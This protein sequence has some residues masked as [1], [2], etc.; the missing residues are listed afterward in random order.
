MSRY[1]TYI[2]GNTVRKDWSEGRP[3]QEGQQ[4]Q[5]KKVSSQVKKNRNKAAHMNKGYVL[6]L[7]AA[8][9]MT[10]IVCVQYIQAQSALTTHA[11][12]VTKLQEELAAAKEE[13]NSAY[14]ALMNSMNLEDIRKRAQEELGMISIS[15]EQI[16]KYQSPAYNYIKQYEAIP[17]SGI[18]VQSQE[19]SGE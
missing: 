12:T 1:Q 16:V 6:F 4:E 13:N 9:V 5:K 19:E 17:K 10:L 15:S 3:Y 14:N 2:D 11:R 18:L 7:A 8:A